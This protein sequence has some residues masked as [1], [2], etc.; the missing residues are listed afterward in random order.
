MIN[1][2]K[3]LNEYKE[4]ETMIRSLGSE[5]K[6][7]EETQ[8]E[9]TEARL[10]MCRTFR[11]YFSHQK[12]P[13]FIEVTDKMLKWFQ[14]MVKKLKTNGD[15]VRKHMKKLDIATVTDKDK[16]ADILPKFKK[17]KVDA[18]P[19]ISSG[20]KDKAQVLGVI[21]LIDAAMA[22]AESKTIKVTYVKMTLKHKFV[23]PETAMEDVPESDQPIIVTSDGTENG[24]ILGVLIT[25]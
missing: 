15:T 19:V 20:A 25:K 6:L 23:T 7:Y 21:T 13:G 12:D 3:F 5:P 18:L 8:D 9:V 22:L 10:R 4:Y 14:G 11:N 17:L 16:C 2:K 24:Q 1:D